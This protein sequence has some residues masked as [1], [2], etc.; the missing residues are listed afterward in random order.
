[1]DINKIEV[2]GEIFPVEDLEA[3]NNITALNNTIA[4]QNQTIAQLLE[5]INNLVI[6]VFNDIEITDIKDKITEVPSNITI[7][8]AYAVKRSGWITLTIIISGNVTATMGGLI[9]GKISDEN[10]WQI[11]G[12]NT[13]S[14]MTGY[15][16][17]NATTDN[18][19]RVI[20]EQTN[21][22]NLAEVIYTGDAQMRCTL[23]YP[24]K[25]P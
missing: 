14:I 18:F 25:N 21:I 24:A 11:D 2:N 23:V 17:D 10:Y 7:K 8:Q 5:K 3:R 9:I 22:I 6:P 4:E 13:N 15:S 1:M 19:G 20:I 12:V 16:N